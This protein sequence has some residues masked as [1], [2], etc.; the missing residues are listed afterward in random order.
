MRERHRVIVLA[1]AFDI[2]VRWY[3]NRFR[4]VALSNRR[5]RQV[6]RECAANGIVD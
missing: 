5:R 3:W 2:D 1:S 6:H 4:N